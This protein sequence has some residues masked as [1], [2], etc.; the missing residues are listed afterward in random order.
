MKQLEAAIPFLEVAESDY[1]KIQL[2]RTR[3]EVIY[4]LAV[5]YHNL[6]IRLESSS[7]PAETREAAAER[8]QRAKEMLKQRDKWAEVHLEVE[9]VSKE[10][11]AMVVDEELQAVLDIVVKAAGVI[12]P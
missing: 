11:A 8:K 6:A 3:L 12:S 1:A 7:D 10:A 9:K 2:Y 4:M 5:V